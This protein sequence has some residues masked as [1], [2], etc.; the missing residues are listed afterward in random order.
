MSPERWA[1]VDELL[2]QALACPAA[3]RTAF[4]N[5]ACGDDAGLRAQVE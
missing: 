3:E 1:Q 5:K 2:A 4:V